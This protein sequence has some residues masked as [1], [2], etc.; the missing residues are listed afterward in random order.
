MKLY[1]LRDVVT[2]GWLDLKPYP[3]IGANNGAD[4]IRRI[5]PELLQQG[6]NFNDIELWEVATLTDSEI[7]NQA[8]IRIEWTQYKMPETKA[9]LLRPLGVTQKTLDKMQ[10]EKIK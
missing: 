6:F 5:V 3:V 1:R 4:A 10:K 7:I 8:P 9:D 2:D